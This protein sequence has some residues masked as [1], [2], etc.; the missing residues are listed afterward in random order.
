MRLLLP[1]LQYLVARTGRLC[2]HTLKHVELPIN[3]NQLCSVELC[4]LAC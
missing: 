1:E 4:V 3:Y 2:W